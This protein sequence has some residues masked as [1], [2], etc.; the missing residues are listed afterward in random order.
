[1]IRQPPRST[2][3]D[4][5]FPYTTLFRSIAQAPQRCAELLARY[6]KD[7]AQRFDADTRRHEIDAASRRFVNEIAHDM[8]RSEEHTSELQSLM[9]ISSA[10]FRLKKKN[11]SQHTHNLPPNT[12]SHMTI[13]IYKSPDK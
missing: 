8:A 1:M 13:I 3:T 10:V 6:A 12:T 4:T 9:R 11:K 7:P 5:L 2:R